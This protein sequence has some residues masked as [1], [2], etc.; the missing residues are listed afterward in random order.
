MKE[1]RIEI[2]L[3]RV[4]LAILSLTIT[5]IVVEEVSRLFL[6]TRSPVEQEFPETNEMRHP[7]PYVM[8]GALPHRRGLNAIGYRG[9]LPVI[10]K[11]PGE[12]RIFMLGGSTVLLGNP[13]IAD[14]LEDEFETAGSPNVKV[15]N[16]GVL[17]SVSGM[18]LT[19]I[20]HEISD[21]EPDLVIMYNGGNDIIVPWESD[22]RPGY[23]FNFAVL[24]SNPLIESTP[25]SY[26]AFA[27]FAYGSNLFRYFLRN[28]FEEQ[29]IHL[30]QL[31]KQTRWK[32]EGWRE[33]IADKYVSNVIKA[34]KISAAFGA[35]FIVF[36]QPMMY[37]KKHLSADEEA[38]F[39]KPG[40]RERGEYA[41]YMRTRI[42][43]KLENVS[44][45][46]SLNW[47][48]LS[49]IYAHKHERIFNDEIHTTDP[50][51]E[52]I[53]QAMYEQINKLCAQ[54]LAAAKSKSTRTSR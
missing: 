12:F 13:P 49:Q 40:M 1:H 38:Y 53:A 25:K 7:K 10:P 44:K 14:W 48:D 33:K 43:L 24:E 28:Y 20:V 42:L 39:N 54:Q 37:F 5:F 32:S 19:R 8:F 6:T 35:E 41:Q 34:G 27:T 15:Y 16:Y 51:K 47:L 4:F 2:F 3:G 45:T 29:F 23:P 30:N 50:A 17:S 21:L 11:K 18:E 9:N 31:R 22:P 26:P 52:T 36:F 46:N